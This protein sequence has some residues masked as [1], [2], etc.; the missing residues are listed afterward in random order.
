MSERPLKHP[1]VD[2]LVAIVRTR[3]D[4]EH[5]RA[6]R[7]YRVP[8]ASAPAALLGGQ[9][10]T[11]A[12]YLPKAFGEYA[13]Q[14]YW[15]APL[16]QTSVAPRRQLLPNEPNHRRADEPYLR[17]ELG[18]LGHL[19]R[20]IRS[21]RLRRI[22]FI[23]TTAAKLEDAEEINDLFHASPLEDTVWTAL[24][25]EGVEAERE[26]FVPGDRSGRYALDFAIFGQE[27]NL[28]IEC[29]GDAYHTDPVKS[30]H[31]NRRNNFLATRG[32]SVLRFTSAQIREELPDVLYQIRSAVKSCGGVARME[33]SGAPSP[34]P[35]R[36][37]ALWDASLAA[38]HDVT[39]RRRATRAVSPPRSG[40]R[41]ARPAHTALTQSE[42]SPAATA[43]QPPLPALGLDYLG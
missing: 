20:P 31:D 10:R 32:W 12:F 27:R 30:R 9:V 29:D 36:Q 34:A 33:S 1:P 4:F 13:W 42:G 24:K 26:F 7:W 23:P 40:R 19:P 5:I 41:A 25:A 17:L 2:A 37:P 43:Q 14:V 16:L 18:P 22:V 39:P 3:A 6:G 21:R 28:N 38:G 35:L 11:L 15:T 8:A